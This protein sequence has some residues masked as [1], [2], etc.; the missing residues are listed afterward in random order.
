M[1]TRILTRAAGMGTKLL[2]SLL[3]LLLALTGCNAPKTPMDTT[4]EETPEVTPGETTEDLV[5]DTTV[6][7]EDTTAEPETEETVEKDPYEALYLLLGQSYWEKKEF[8][9]KPY[10][11]SPYLS[12]GGI[13]HIRFEDGSIYLESFLYRLSYVE[14]YQIEPDVGV[15]RAAELLKEES[16]NEVYQERIEFLNRIQLQNKWYMLE[17]VSATL[18]R[19]VIYVSDD[20]LYFLEIGT[21]PT[22]QINWIVRIHFIEYTG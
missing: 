19:F 9:A 5:E 15:L 11:R 2:L 20:I 22:T 16:G 8:S 13:D 14:N 1:K 12:S 7:I 10:L 17:Q 3:V 18:H 21:D 4:P 6:P